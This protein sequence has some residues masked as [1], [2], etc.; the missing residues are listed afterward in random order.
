[1]KPSDPSTVKTAM[2]EAQLLSSNCGQQFVV[3][4][5]DQQIYKVII[6][7][8][9]A[10]PEVFS[11]IYPRLGGLHTIM[12]FSGSVGK[13]MMDSG[14]SEILKHA[15]GGVDKMLSGR[16]FIQNLR[17]FRMLT[18][19]LLRK[20][21]GD[22]ETYEDLDAM[23]TDI[24]NRSETAKLWVDCFVRPTLIMMVFIR[25]ERESDWPLHLWAVS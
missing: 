21:M 15:F 24:S 6:D 1:M 8:I 23:L 4:T 14:L 11:N 3:I 16:K 13:L 20:H 22:V 7:N 5:A 10:T 12:S 17:A 18:E 2:V 25:A 9:W 19:E